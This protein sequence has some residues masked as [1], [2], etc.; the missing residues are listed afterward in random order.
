MSYY[1]Y[2]IIIFWLFGLWQVRQWHVNRL[3][4]MTARL[5]VLDRKNWTTIADDLLD[6][7]T[8]E[9]FLATNN[10]GFDGSR[11]ESSAPRWKFAGALL[12]SVTV[13]TTIGKKLSSVESFNVTPSQSYVVLLAI[14][15][16]ITQVNTSLLPDTTEHILVSTVIPRHHH[17]T[18]Y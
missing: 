18:L 10:K 6:N 4:T 16:Q 15:D 5:N 13:I 8:R 17:L 2:Y 12:Y 3:W 11:D 14:W 7:L 1:Y 9:V